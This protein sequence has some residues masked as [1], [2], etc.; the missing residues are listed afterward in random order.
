MKIE[1]EF[2]FCQDLVK[3][4]ITRKTVGKSGRVFSDLGALSTLNNLYVLRHLMMEFKPKRTLEIGLCF[5]GSGLVFTSTH[6]E[7]GNMPSSQHTALDPFQT[8]AWDDSGVAAIEHAGLADYFDFRSAFSAHELP[9]LISEGS[10]FDLIYVD[11]S[12]LFEDVFLDAYFS[13]R[14]LTPSGIVAF[15]DACDPHVA[16]VLKFLRRNF[17]DF[18]EEIDLSSHRLDRGQSFR[19]RIAKMLGRTQMRAFRVTGHPERKWDA[20]FVDF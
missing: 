8:I 6:Q 17:S 11:G 3:M 18:I 16:K 5:G 4:L 7:L 12:H 9:Q 19:Y 2:G 13:L 14:L 20:S 15:D 10:R 1:K